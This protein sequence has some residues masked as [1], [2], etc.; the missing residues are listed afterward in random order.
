MW[1]SGVRPWCTLRRDAAYL[2]HPQPLDW[3]ALVPRY[4]AEAVL[5]AP[6]ERY[7]RCESAADMQKHG[8]E[9]CGGGPTAQVM[10]AVMASR[11][12]LIGPDYGGS[13]WGPPP[14]GSYVMPWLWPLVILR[15]ET[16][17]EWC[18]RDDLNARPPRPHTL[19][20]PA[21]AEWPVRG[22][23][24]ERIFAQWRFF[25]D[26]ASCER[27]LDPERARYRAAG[28]RRWPPAGGAAAS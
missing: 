27:I 3:F 8:A 28:A 1:L 2:A 13:K 17:N 6:Y 21:V 7:R 26:Q 15:D 12:P 23:S 25:Y 22:G 18:Q 14:P 4:L 20:A 9:C 19:L 24:V 11:V 10:G 5:R 16:L